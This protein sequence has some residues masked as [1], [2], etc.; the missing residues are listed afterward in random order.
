MSYVQS[1]IRGHILV[2]TLNRPEARNAFNA[3]MAAEMEAIIDR[4]EADPELRV[5]V[6]RAEGDTFCAGQDLKEAA[7]GKL[8]LAKLPTFAPLAKIEAL[9]VL[10]PAPLPATLPTTRYAVFGAKPAA[11][12]SCPAASAWL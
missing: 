5:A 6:L 9:S 8:A 12:E 2:I 10:A 3:E 1:E 11:E 4:Y 7:Q